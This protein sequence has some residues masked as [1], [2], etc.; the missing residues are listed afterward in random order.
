MRI[1][2]LFV[3]SFIKLCVFDKHMLKGLKS[4]T[5]FRKKFGG[6]RKMYYFCKRV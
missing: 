6:F 1:A 3:K 5:S 2:L 4:N